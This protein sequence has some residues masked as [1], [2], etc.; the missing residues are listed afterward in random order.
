MLL[1]LVTDDPGARLV[2]FRLCSVDVTARIVE[3]GLR[4]PQGSCA[5]PGGHLGVASIAGAERPDRFAHGLDLFQ[6]APD[7]GEFAHGFRDILEGGTIEGAKCVGECFREAP[8]IRVFGQLRLAQL[9]QRVDQRVIAFGP[10]MKQLLIHGA[11]INLRGGEYLAMGTNGLDQA[12][13]RKRGFLR[14]GQPQIRADALFGDE[15]PGFR[16]VTAGNRAQP[17]AQGQ[18][19]HLPSVVEASELDPRVAGTALVALVHQQIPFHALAAVAVR[20][21][22]GSAQVGIQEKRQRKRQH[23]GF[24]GAI[25]AAKHQVT[26]AEPELLDVVVIQLDQAEAQRLPA[27]SSGGRQRNCGWDLGQVNGSEMA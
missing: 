2:E 16:S 6:V 19:Q 18:R 1:R 11:T 12:L 27:G 23:F 24:T 14:R 5:A 10:Q 25:V 22:A 15:E 8:L 9:N 20:F 13:P 4:L 17:A 7:V 3:I 26:V 21:D